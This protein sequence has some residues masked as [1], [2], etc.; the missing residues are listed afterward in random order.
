MEVKKLV[1]KLVIGVVSASVFGLFSM[2]VKVEK[3]GEWKDLATAKVQEQDD[4]MV[5]MSKDIFLLND[6]I[7]E[8]DKKLDKDKYIADTVN[9]QQLD[10]LRDK[11][12]DERLNELH[13]TIEELEKGE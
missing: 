12:I 2:H 7:K 9:E 8:I 4:L 3:M 11:I 1:D 10:Q 6:K 5:Q 13:E